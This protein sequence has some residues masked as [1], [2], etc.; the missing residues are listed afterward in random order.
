MLA[1]F[2]LTGIEI[3]HLLQNDCAPRPNTYESFRVAPKG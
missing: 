2:A 1:V 3:Y